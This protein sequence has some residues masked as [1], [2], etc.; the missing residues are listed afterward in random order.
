MVCYCI[1]QPGGQHG[2]TCKALRE[3]KCPSRLMGT[4]VLQIGDNEGE[5]E[6]LLHQP[7]RS[8]PKGD[9]CKGARRSHGKRTNLVFLE[10]EPDTYHQR[11][12]KALVFVDVPISI[13]RWAGKRAE[14]FPEI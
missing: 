13:R 4:I 6:R 14:P 10:K 7:K 8:Q 9:P 3:A 11:R 1:G 5:N 12:V 2:E